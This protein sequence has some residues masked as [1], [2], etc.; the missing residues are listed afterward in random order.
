MIL[1]SANGEKRRGEDEVQ[2][3]HVG[4][5]FTICDRLTSRGNNSNNNSQEYEVDTL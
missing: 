5:R 4:F 1:Q 3:G 2:M